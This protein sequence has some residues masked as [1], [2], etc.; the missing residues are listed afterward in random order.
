MTGSTLALSEF[1]FTQILTTS[2]TSSVPNA[3]VV[4]LHGED[5]TIAYAAALTF[6]LGSPI[7]ITV[8]ASGQ[9][10]V[11][12][13]ASGTD[14]V[15]TPNAYSS[16][17]GDDQNIQ[18][19]LIRLPERGD[20]VVWAARYGGQQTAGIA[21]QG[22]HHSVTVG[23]QVILDVQGNVW[24]GGE[25][26]AV[27]MPVTADA[28]KKNCGCGRF[29]GDGF[30]AKFSGDGAR[31]LYATYIGGSIPALDNGSQNDYVTSAAMDGAGHIWAVG[32]TS[33]DFPTAPKGMHTFGGGGLGSRGAFIIEYDPITN[34]LLYSSTF[35]GI[36]SV[37]V[38]NV[39]I[40]P[41]GTVVL[42][43]SLPNYLV[44]G[45]LL[46][47]PMAGFTRIAGN[48][49]SNSGFAATIDPG[50]Y[51]FSPVAFPPGVTSGL[52]F[53]PAGLPVIASPNNFV[54]VVQFGDG[55]SP[56][57][58]AIA[59]MGATNPSG[60]VSPGELISIYGVN[61][62]P[63]TAVTADLSLG[64]V[65]TQ[66]GG[67]QVLADEEPLP[68]LYVQNDQIDAMVPFHMAGK[69][70]IRVLVINGGIPSEQALL[71]VVEAQPEALQKNNRP[72]ALNED[73]MVNTCG[74]PA[75][76][77]GIVSV[78]GTGFGDPASAQGAQ[79]LFDGA[80][81]EITYSGQAAGLIAGVTQ[82]NFRLP[83]STP[84]IFPQFQFSV[85][86]WLS[87]SFSLCVN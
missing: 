63:A 43:G 27:D 62:G 87:E 55:N 32:S 36:G 84:D 70:S 45:T 49:L 14:F 75:Q 80:P 77:G 17:A 23:A 2:R 85:D 44:Q 53:T 42:S 81:L 48:A 82:V 40:A 3:F 78:F 16:P 28:L 37:A 10:L 59:N 58:Y 5:G 12:G 72:A 54:G 56:S 66:L 33:G 24:V 86:G 6:T 51:E 60:Q 71:G 69:Q 47:V 35:G 7:G 46:G 4:K 38:G 15:T 76:R 31:L 1:P 39:A 52:A 83:A 79:T 8:D 41:V 13:Y 30:L 73:G 22:V 34:R 29:A 20:R 18:T 57:I 26:H 64:E 61:I 68:L 21:N 65:P 50:T 25:T 19:A 67:V 11:L 9:A 74:R